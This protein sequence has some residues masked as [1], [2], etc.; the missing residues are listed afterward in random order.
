MLDPVI[1]SS[2]ISGVGNLLGSV[3]GFK[4]QK[5]TNEANMELA[6]YQYEKNLE[7][8]N[9]N[10]EYNT[11]AN[12]V[13]R[14]KDAGLNPALMYGSGS[15]ANTS[16]SMPEYKAPTL[17]AYT[18]FGSLGLDKFAQIP[19][20]QAQIRNLEANTGLSE[21]RTAT[22][23]QN[24]LLTGYKAEVEEINKSIKEA[25]S[26]KDWTALKYWKKELRLRLKKMQADIG[27]TSEQIVNEGFKRGLMSAQTEHTKSL[28]ETVDALRPGQLRNQEA[29]YG[30][31]V[32]RT[33]K[34]YASA[35]ESRA[36]IAYYNALTKLTD[37]QTLGIT[38]KQK[39]RID[40]EIAKLEVDID[41]G[42]VKN[43]RETIQLGLDQIL[44]DNGVDP[45][46]PGYAGWLEKFVY[47]IDQHIGQVREWSKSNPH[48]TSSG[49]NT[50]GAWR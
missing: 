6:K 44:R 39:E 12:Q 33:A 3:F 7:M 13:Q 22:E 21:Q 40:N 36:H 41:A 28:K 20:Q 18:D 10:N 5:D 27:L 15:V 37:A 38:Y 26:R 49:R 31:I 11:P 14:M 32:S 34:N 46:N 2:I 25:Q 43:D 4:S 24:T 1:G 47:A 17:Q 29:E 35:A 45:R 16:T 50:G 19:L 8:W 30:E 42:R 48:P 23:I 9:R